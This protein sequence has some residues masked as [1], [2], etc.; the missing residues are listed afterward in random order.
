MVAF[1]QQQRRWVG[2]M[3]SLLERL[4]ETAKLRQ[5]SRSREF[6]PETAIGLGRKIELLARPWLSMA[7]RS[8]AHGLPVSVWC[9]SNTTRTTTRMA[10]IERGGEK[11]APPRRS[12]LPSDTS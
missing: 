8:C 10:W 6:W 5:L 11:S 9:S 4:V 1:I 3:P 2:D 7:C 12:I